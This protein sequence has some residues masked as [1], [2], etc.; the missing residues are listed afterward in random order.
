MD[1]SNETCVLFFRLFVYFL[2]FRGPGGMWSQGSV[3]RLGP[4][5][6]VLGRQWDVVQSVK[7]QIKIDNSTWS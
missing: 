7:F 6:R 2:L 3:G 4:R 1:D 5:T